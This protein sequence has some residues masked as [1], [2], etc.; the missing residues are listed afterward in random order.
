MQYA[1]SLIDKAIESCGSAAELARKMGIDRAEVTK[2]KQGKRPLSPELA[3][4]LADIAGDDA[5]E[6]AIHAIIER[7]A[8]GRKGHLLR[9]ILGKALAAGVVGM[10]VFS[11]NGDS[12]SATEKIANKLDSLYIVSSRFINWF[13]GVLMRCMGDFTGVNRALAFG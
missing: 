10:W 1:E 3:A 8:E 13:R 9:E 11:Y 5:R 6:A 4:E 12:I 2:L 7:N